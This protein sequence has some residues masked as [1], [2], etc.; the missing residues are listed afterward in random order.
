M[1]KP[2]PR[3]L[4]CGTIIYLLYSWQEREKAT[5]GQ[6]EEEPKREYPIVEKLG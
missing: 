5:C 2:D 6:A 4:F 1:Y 3:M